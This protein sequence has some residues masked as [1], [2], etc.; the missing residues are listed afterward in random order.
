MALGLVLLRG[1][2][3]PSAPKVG[4]SLPGVLA[5]A[6]HPSGALVAQNRSPADRLDVFEAGINL[7]ARSRRSNPQHTCGRRHS[8]VNVQDR[9]IFLN[10]KKRENTTK[11]ASVNLL[12]FCL[13]N[14]IRPI[15]GQALYT[16]HSLI[17]PFFTWV[18]GF[19]GPEQYKPTDNDIYSLRSKL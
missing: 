11:S 15:L 17:G 19:V 8:H 3:S 7:W 6:E 2:P 18:V 9:N 14:G 16:A 1:W 12:K 10:L 13:E 4:F 5:G